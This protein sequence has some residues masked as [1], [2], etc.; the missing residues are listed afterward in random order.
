MKNPEHILANRAAGRPVY[1]GLWPRFKASVID[2]VICFVAPGLISS[3][4]LTAISSAAIGNSYDSPEGYGTGLVMLVA[5]LAAIVVL[6]WVSCVLG[7]FTYFWTRG[8]SIGM[9]AEG[10]RIAHL[11]TG[12]PPGCGRALARSLLGLTLVAP[13]FLLAAAGFSDAP[14]GYSVARDLPV[15]GSALLLGAGLLGQ[16]WMIWDRRKQTVLDKL[17]GVVFIAE[18][19]AERQGEPAR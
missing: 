18:P 6:F 2:W 10:I 9:R 1:A 5:V 3:L 11:E 16:L 15:L 4:A 8:Q 19:T 17:C 12:R 7:Y 14:S 13:A